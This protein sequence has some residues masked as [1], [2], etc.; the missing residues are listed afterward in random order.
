MKK[1]LV[2]TR[3]FIAVLALGLAL[4]GCDAGGGGSNPDVETETLKYTGSAENGEAFAV[5]ITQTVA[6][7][8]Q[9][10][11]TYVLSINGSVVQTGRL[12]VNGDSVTLRHRRGTPGPPRLRGTR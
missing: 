3:I 7:A 2:L 5:A 8:I 9:D 1:K 11:A 4:A 12:R 6:R 10:R